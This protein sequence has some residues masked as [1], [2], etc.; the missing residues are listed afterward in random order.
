MPL[1]PRIT[2][3]AARLRPVRPEDCPGGPTRVVDAGGPV[4]PAEM[5][6]CRLCHR[7]HLPAV[8][9]AVVAPREDGS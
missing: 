9:E 2:R 5:P 1:A 8:K 7:P 3:L 6:R 4:D